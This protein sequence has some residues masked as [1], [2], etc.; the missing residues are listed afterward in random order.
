M[1]NRGNAAIVRHSSPVADDPQ[2]MLIVM[3][4]RKC[5]RREA[6]WITTLC[7]VLRRTL[8]RRR[9]AAP[10]A[11]SR[12]ATTRMSALAPPLLNSSGLAKRTETL[13]DPERRRRY[14]RQ[15]RASRVQ[16]VVIREVMV[17]GPFPEPLFASRRDSFAPSRIQVTAT[18]SFFD[19][20]VEEFFA[21]FDDDLF[22]PRRRR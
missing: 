16:P 14:D 13:A 5:S 21:S 3:S 8:T 15:L 2:R 17:S 6:R 4:A 1:V 9:S 19:Q 11:R 10:F 7:S 12:A 22:W 20:I 18:R